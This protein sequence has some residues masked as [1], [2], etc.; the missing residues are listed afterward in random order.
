MV[1][2][3]CHWVLLKQVQT[4]MTASPEKVFLIMCITCLVLLPI[5]DKTIYLAKISWII[6]E[7]VR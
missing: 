1:Y 7:R 5:I 3:L 2:Y 4:Y 6:G